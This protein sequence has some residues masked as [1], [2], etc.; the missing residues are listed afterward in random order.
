MN[1][2]CLRFIRFKFMLP[3]LLIFFNHSQFLTAVGKPKTKLTRVDCE[4]QILY[5]GGSDMGE[6]RHEREKI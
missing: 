4:L 1:L 5:A 6:K 2:T 3:V